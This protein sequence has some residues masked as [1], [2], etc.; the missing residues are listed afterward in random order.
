M[1]FSVAFFLSRLFPPVSVSSSPIVL[2]SFAHLFD[3]LVFLYSQL[4]LLVS[5]LSQLV[6]LLILSPYQ[7]TTHL[8]LQAL[9]D[10]KTLVQSTEMVLFLSI[11][12]A[13]TFCITLLAY[14]SYLL[15]PFYIY[16]LSIPYLIVMS[17]SY[18]Q[19]CDDDRVPGIAPENTCLTSFTSQFAI[20]L[21]SVSFM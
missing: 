18:L 13:F 6:F 10:P 2:C 3:Y 8:I 14:C 19:I 9:L 12:Y 15:V 4:L 1:C 16:I 7:I 21:V 5:L 11:I 17:N 20:Q